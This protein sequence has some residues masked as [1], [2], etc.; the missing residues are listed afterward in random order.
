ML[1]EIVDIPNGWAT[2]VAPSLSA[3]V[4]LG[5][6][7]IGFVLR[8]QSRRLR[9]ITRNTRVTVEQVANDHDSNLRVEQDNRH[10]EITG[11][12]DIILD[13]VN[14]QG[15]D[16]GGMREDIRGL[17]STTRELT[18]RQNRDREHVDEL[19]KSI[20]R[21]RVRQIM[22]ESKENG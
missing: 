9:E 2:V 18:R 20:P 14:T 8:N 3:V 5:G 11:K 13:M 4:G 17:H 12:I 1:S 6:A 15:K 10:N 22:E 21:S 19:E 16:I 7:A